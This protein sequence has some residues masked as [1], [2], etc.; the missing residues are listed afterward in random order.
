[1]VQLRLTYGPFYKSMT[2]RG[3]FSTECT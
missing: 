1:V 2:T 3:H